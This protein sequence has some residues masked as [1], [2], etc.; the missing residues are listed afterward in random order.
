[1]IDV[2][3]LVAAP[4]ALVVTVAGVTQWI[5]RNDYVPPRAPDAAAPR[6]ALPAP[7]VA[8]EVITG[9]TVEVARPLALPAGVSHGE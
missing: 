6:R 1:M 8:G 5:R 7:V 4:A 2:T 9:V 3:V